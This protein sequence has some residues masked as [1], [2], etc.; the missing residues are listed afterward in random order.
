MNNILIECSQN[1]SIVNKDGDFETTLPIPIT[2]ENGDSFLLSKTFIDNEIESEGIIPIPEDL[3]LEIRVIPYIMNDDA[4]KFDTAQTENGGNGVDNGEYI[5]YTID[6]DTSNPTNPK[7][8]E[9][10]KIRFIYGNDSNYD[11]HFG[12]IDGQH[13]VKFTAQDFNGNP[14]STY[15]DIPF[16][17]LTGDDENSI[18]VETSIYCLKIEKSINGISR[19][20][21][22]VADNTNGNW[23]RSKCVDVEGNNRPS[24]IITG[25]SNKDLV[26]KKLLT[27]ASFTTSIK[28]PSEKY[29][30]TD[31]TTLINDQLNENLFTKT[32]QTIG[33]IVDTPFLHQSFS[34]TFGK[35]VSNKILI[36]AKNPFDNLPTTANIS[37]GS[38]GIKNPPSNIADY[39]TNFLIG[40]NLVELAYSDDRSRFYWNFLHG[41]IYSTSPGNPIVTRLAKTGGTT[42][43][44]ATFI[45]QGKNGG[46]F[47]SN[48]ECYYYNNV[49]EKIPFDFIEGILGFQEGNLIPSS[50]TKVFSPASNNEYTG[51]IY[52]LKDGV[53]TTNAG[54][55]MDSAVDKKNYQRIDVQND[56][57]ATSVFN[58]VIY[59]DIEVAGN[60]ILDTPYYLV[61]IH[62]N[63]SS[64]VISSDSI[65]RNITGII[66][67][68]YSKGS[69]VSSGG[70]PSFVINYKGEPTIIHSLRIRILNPDRTL[71]TVGSNN[72]LFF[73]LI[74]AN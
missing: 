21:S 16:T 59:A 2:I 49:G 61:E 51:D 34:F 15:V 58:N 35:A 13:P 19:N 69:Y 28:I 24:F 14:F 71:A 40:T 48:F 42:I 29:S 64:N 67:R 68:Y 62:L 32:V 73:E 33:D 39:D 17:K 63:F 26:Q 54:F 65:T 46:V 7:M 41:P 37:G 30:I 70:D 38:L 72:I 44:N 4:D 8:N 66:N 20:A 50:I 18:E 10:T 12:D 5:L 3:T 6:T 57:E 52:D 31:L 1:N 9:I 23:T 27:P 55:V 11:T 56:F 60:G 43:Q 22:L 25:T 47:F 36:P 74:K 53:H 45:Q